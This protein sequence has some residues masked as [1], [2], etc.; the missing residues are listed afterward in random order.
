MSPGMLWFGPS[1]LTRPS[2]WCLDH[3][4]GNDQAV[5]VR[6][7][8]VV[9][10]VLT[11]S[12][13]FGVS[14][15]SAAHA[16][17]RP[18]NDDYG[19]ATDLGSL[20]DLTVFGT[21]DFATA[22]GPDSGLPDV[23]YRWTPP[24]AGRYQVTVLASEGIS[25]LFFY[26]GDA[27][28]AAERRFPNGTKLDQVDAVARLTVDQPRTLTIGVTARPLFDPGETNPFFLVIEPLNG[29][30]PPPND[31]I[32]QS[33]VLG[34]SVVVRFDFPLA[35]FSRDSGG[36]LVLTTEAVEPV[37]SSPVMW[38]E[39]TAPGDGFLLR[40]FPG[41]VLGRNEAT[42]ELEAAPLVDGPVWRSRLSSVTGGQQYFLAVRDDNGRQGFEYFAELPLCNG[43]EPTIIAG[44]FDDEIT[45]TTDAD[46]ILAGAGN[47]RLYAGVG[48]DALCGGRGNDVIRGGPGR[49]VIAGGLGDDRIIG[50]TWADTVTFR[51]SPAPVLVDLE[52]GRASGE[53]DD[54][55]LG[56]ENLVGSNHADVLTGDRSPNRLVGGAGD[57]KL[58]GADGRDLLIG[59][60]GDDAIDGGGGLNDHASFEDS[61]NG[62]VVD[63]ATGEATGQGEDRLVGIEHVIGSHHSD[64]IFG[65]EHDNR[66]FGRPGDDLLDGRD[67][68]DRIHGGRGVDICGPSQ[69]SGCENFL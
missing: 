35:G 50:G 11:A 25:E 55:L 43:Q 62:V 45:G 47:D 60:A 6:S 67:G 20:A 26:E 8:S 65:D 69:R 21:T 36:D 23:W 54:T 33:V 7:R 5:T 53:G 24:S 64:Q 63:L 40:S 38:Y 57:D 4:R 31:L 58:I 56:V 41:E 49:D 52:E 22:D 1:A 51:G 39:W 15:S 37:L 42:G 10:L 12:V 34:S 44:P 3:A 13:L 14:K 30:N 16:D 9:A 28:A 27:V 66:I 32:D 68:N 61:P 17:E 48:D 29:L 18:E 46:V 2:S 19:E 59:G